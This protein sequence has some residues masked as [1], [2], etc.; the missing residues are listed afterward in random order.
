MGSRVDQCARGIAAVVTALAALAFLP[1]T[2]LGHA[3]LVA[4]VP[5]S[6]AVVAVAPTELRLAFSEPLEA[7][8]STASLLGPTGATVLADAGAPD[9]ADQLILVVPLTGR[10]L[11]PGTYTV[12]WRSLSA[13]DGHTAAGAFTFSIGRPSAGGAGTGAGTAAAA[14]LHTHDA[15]EIEAKSLLLGGFIL[16]FGLALIAWTVFGQRGAPQAITIGLGIALLVG[17]A[18]AALSIAVSAAELTTILVPSAVADYAVHSRPG[19]LL[20]W[21]VVAGL[22][23]GVAV[24][25]LARWRR[26]EAALELGIL[27][28]TAALVLTA[29]GGHAAAFASPAPVAMDIVHLGSAG[30]WLAGLMVL[31]GLASVGRLRGP[32]ARAVVGRFSSLALV[33]IAL[34]ALTGTYA[35]WIETRDFT[36]IADPY[37]RTLLVKVILAVL[38]FAIGGLNYLDGGRGLAA[39]GMLARLAAAT[40]VGGLS[41]RVTIEAGLAISVVVVTAALTTGAPSAGTRPVPVAEAATTG[42]VGLPATFA[43]GPARPGPNRAVVQVPGASAS[44]SVRL[45]LTGTGGGAT[46]VVPLVAAPDDPAGAVSGDVGALPAGTTFEAIVIATGPDGTELARHRFSFELGDDGLT[47]GRAVPPV[48]PAIAIAVVL[49]ALGVLAVV[50][51]LAGGSPP[52]VDPAAGRWALVVGGALGGIVGLVAL[53]AGPNL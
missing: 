9:P 27:A 15:S 22:G 2:T 41:R 3:E 13:A 31:A 40:R 33:S 30:T 24:L 19:L 47:A 26:Q 6:G 36:S 5:A 17:A 10:Q 39:R 28:A 51:G 32:D 42:A 35:A 29:I 48:D 21:R 44:T 45:E 11:D 37:P 8:Y 1:G 53:V 12:S 46:V 25:V 20:S 50:F 16:A 34:V 14:G 7:G 43:I 52:R 49:L 38:A 18:G 23:G 4:T